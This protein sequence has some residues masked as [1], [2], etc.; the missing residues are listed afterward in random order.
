MPQV[1]VLVYIPR[2][3]AEVFAFLADGCN[4]ARWHSGVADIRAEG[5]DYLYRFPGRRRETRLARSLCAEGSRVSFL[6]DRLWTPL[7]SQS[8]RHDFRVSPRGEGCHV[9]IQVTVRLWGGMLALWPVVELGWRRDLPE[10]ARRLY[11]LLTGGQDPAPSA[12]ARGGG[13][14][15]R[16]GERSR[17]G[18][19]P[20]R[21]LLPHRRGVPGP[22]SG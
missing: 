18:G 8:P 7:G 22:S 15:R 5:V 6:G 21:A 1:D 4:L 14:G 2:P 16:G 3:A 19:L 20:L 10:D 12:V 13:P 17:G 11:R 9:D